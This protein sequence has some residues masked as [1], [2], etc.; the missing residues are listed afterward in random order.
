MV[1]NKKDSAWQGLTDKQKNYAYYMSEAGMAGAKMIPHQR[2]YESPP[3]FMLLS[4]FFQDKNLDQLTI[5]I[6]Q[7]KKVD[8]KKFLHFV[9]YSSGV[10]ENYSNYNN[11]GNKKF[12]PELEPAEFEAIF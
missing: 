7:S 11:F 5:D 12:I 9:L 2:S 3:L 6:R 4:A 8:V 1:S 10:F